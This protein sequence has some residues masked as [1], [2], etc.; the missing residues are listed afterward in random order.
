MT[1]K[2]QILK[3]AEVEAKLRM[4]HTSFWRLRKN[5]DFPKPLSLGPR[6][7]G[8]REDSIDRWLME[9]DEMKK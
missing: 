5:S 7:I 8:W 2:I 6:S 1:F 9:K 4:S 3:Q